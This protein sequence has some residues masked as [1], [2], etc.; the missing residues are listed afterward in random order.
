MGRTVGVRLLTGERDYS[1]LHSVKTDSGAHPA[2]CSVGTGGDVPGVK[3]PVRE[4]EHSRSSGVEV[5]NDG[6]MPPLSHI[7]S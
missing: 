7:S 3:W 5:K 2:Y 1:L 4:A 6:A